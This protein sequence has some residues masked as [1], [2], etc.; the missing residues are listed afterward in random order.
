MRSRLGVN[1]QELWAR[2]FRI[3]RMI[4]EYE[5]AITTALAVASPA[6]VAGQPSHL[7][8]DGMEFTRELLD[9]SML[10]AREVAGLWTQHT[11]LFR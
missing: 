5:K 8:S 11:R 6:A 4:P 1:A 10:S 7:R 2:R 3:D 9:E